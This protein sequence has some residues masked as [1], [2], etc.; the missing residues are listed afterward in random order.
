MRVSYQHANIRGGNES[1][2]VR[3]TADDGTRACVLIDSG[4]GV[5][6][7]SLLG[8]DEYLNAILLTHAH[9][10]HYRTLAKNTIHSAPI[11]TAPSTATV[12]EHAL[13][14]AQKDNDLGNVR[15]ALEAVEPITAWTSILNALEVR[16]VPAGHTPGGAG[17]VLRFRDESDPAQQLD[18]EHHILATGDFTTRP[19]AGYAG[20]PTEYPFEIDAVLLNVATSDS[21]TT[22]CNESIRTILERASAGSRI[23]VACSSLTGVRYAALLGT[24]IETL[25]R[26][27]PVSIVGQAAKLYQSLEIDVP[28]VDAYDVFESPTE[29]LDHGGITIAGPNTPTRGSTRRL[30]RAIKTDPDGVFVQLSATDQRGISNEQCTTYRYECG[31]HPDTAT[32]DDVV[33]RLAP[34][35]VVLKHASGYK[36]KELQRRF[37]RCFTW[38]TDDS[39]QYRL[40]DNGEWQAPGWISE[41]AEKQIRR[42]QWHANRELPIRTDSELIAVR[43]GEIDLEAEGVDIVGLEEIFSRNSPQTHHAAVVDEKTACHSTERLENEENSQEA[44]QARQETTTDTTESAHSVREEI[45]D[46]LTEIE[47][48]LDRTERTVP[49]RV[50]DGGDETQ[51]LQL[52]ETTDIE[53]GNVVEVD[54]LVHE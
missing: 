15:D 41:K 43:R 3:F 52:L 33:K 5:D 53:P 13:P 54:I 48:T 50:L 51:F 29:V 16:P 20:L 1:S 23:V 10:D 39:E 38:G 21:P 27:I 44:D 9:I 18:N 36:L 37:D 42:N 46:R 6:V 8:E 11:Y 31:N 12:L 22:V 47:A 2:L 28:G 49:A 40:Y 45:R 26:R 17:F 7:D 25:G 34:K 19:C 30:F 32:I 14:E 35:E 4:A 24:T